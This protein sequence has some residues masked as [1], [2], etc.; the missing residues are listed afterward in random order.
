MAC[1]RMARETELVIRVGLVLVA[2]RSGSGRLWRVGSE[3]HHGLWMIE[4]LGGD[5]VRARS[6]R[7]G[8]WQGGPRSMQRTTA[9]LRDAQRWRE[10]ETFPEPRVDDC[11]YG[12][13]KAG[14]VGLYS[15][16]VRVAS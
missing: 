3:V 1:G 5:V 9:E 12:C 6:R 15:E 2:V 7:T 13:C 10:A 14:D 16:V 11:G 4:P 8:R